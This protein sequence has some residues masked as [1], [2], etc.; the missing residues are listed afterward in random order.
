ME[1]VDR[2]LLL[3]AASENSEQAHRELTNAGPK[4][5]SVVW[6]STRRRLG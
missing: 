1:R 6:K 4:L 5:S 2:D 3:T